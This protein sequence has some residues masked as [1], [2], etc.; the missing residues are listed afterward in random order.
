MNNENTAATREKG[1]AEKNRGKHHAGFFLFTFLLVLVML[2]TM[3]FSTCI[4]Y[5]R[6]VD[7]AYAS[8]RS[9]MYSLRSL[10]SFEGKLED[11]FL[12]ISIQEINLYAD[13]TKPFFD[14]TGVSQETLNTCNAAWMSNALYYYPDDGRPITSDN[15]D[16]FP[17]DESQTHTLRTAGILF[18]GDWVYSAVR[19]LDGWLYIQWGRYENI[20]NMDFPRIADACPSDLCIIE[21]ATGEIMVSTGEQSYDFLDESRV[22]LDEKRNLHA[23]DGIQ[24]GY[25]RGKL[26][27]SGV[28]FEKSRLLDRYSVFVFMPFRTVMANTL[29]K[30]LPIHGLILL[31]FLF[32]WFSS[33]KLR[34]K[35]AALLEQRMCLPV[36]RRRCFSLPMMRHITPLL[37]A[38]IL[39]TSAIAAY[40]PLLTNYT[41]HNT[42]MEKNLQTFIKEI[43]LNDE[44]WKKMEDIYKRVV[45]GHI[46]MIDFFANTMGEDFTQDNLV[47]L[48]QRMNYNSVVIYDGDGVSR[49]STTGYTGYTISQ[50]PNDQEYTLWNLLKNADTDIMGELSDKSGFYAASRRLF[51]KPGL[52]CVTLP[53]DSLVEMKEQTDIRAALLRINTETYAKMYAAAAAPETFLWATSS[54]AS[55]RP[56]ANTLPETV[57]MNR[58][59]G[60]QIINGYDY[61][62]NT[63]T[64]DNH[65]LISVEQSQVFIEPIRKILNVIV[66]EVL[67]LSLLILCAVCIYPCPAGWVKKESAQQTLIRLFSQE[68][69]FPLPGEEALRMEVRK[70]CSRLLWILCGALVLLYFIDAL[71]SNHPISA[72]LFSHQWQREPSI[73]SLTTILLSVLFLACGM[74]LLRTVLQALSSRMDS[75][76]ETFSNLVLSIIQFLL[77]VVVVIYSLHELG[78]DTRVILTSAGVV[79]LIIGYGSQ[80]IV[81]DLVSGIFLIMEDQVRI[82]ETIEI[83]G[84][85]GRVDHIGLRTTRA[86]YGNRTKV[87]SNSK[88]VGFYNLSRDASSASWSIGLSQSVDPETVKSLIAA[89]ADRFKA[90][91]GD[92]LI[93]GPVYLGLNKIRWGRQYV[94]LFAS[95]CSIADWYKVR[96]V[97]MEI[98]YK[99]LTENGIRPVSGELLPL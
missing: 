7:D 29:W 97:S 15:A 67:F 16:A 3:A 87:I 61:Y 68:K 72:Y 19:L 8:L 12:N 2:L 83:D 53:D 21:N 50:N 13:L 64:D 62:L 37:L 6:E 27:L 77:T 69:A 26:P 59:C 90:A 18:Q 73:F 75:R 1:K 78:V 36:G 43:Q 99:I 33:R 46:S 25:Y 71:H 93:R 38:G 34:E 66:P 45:W 56:I 55:V 80:S 98:T 76:A 4:Q 58:Y 82:G 88:M 9:S 95:Y 30:T 20:Y 32:I 65:V 48:A 63:M 52:I 10:I 47:D 81:S 74:K 96:S 51:G 24:A 94:L 28:F 44:E 91:L 70:K 86:S 92:K 22:T 42:K 14:Y 11:S 54:S 5:A 17:L 85:L 35:G 39:T 23:A 40:L 57:L 89:N 79:S 31:C 49:M 41:G 84:F 60:T